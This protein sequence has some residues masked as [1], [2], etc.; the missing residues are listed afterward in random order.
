LGGISGANSLCAT[1]AAAAGYGGTWKAFLSSSGQNVRDL[2]TGTNAS[3]LPVVNTR[4]ENMWAN[5]NTVFTQASWN[6]GTAQYMWSFNGKFVDEGQ[7]TPDWF[8]ADGWHGSTATGLVHTYTCSD[9]T[10]TA[11]YGANG[12]WDFGT[13]FN[14]EADSCAYTLAVACVSIP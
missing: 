6:T 12:E 5:W 1:Q 14:T 11:S 13:M 2:I 7:T 8:D 3:T 4:G 9:W 10:S